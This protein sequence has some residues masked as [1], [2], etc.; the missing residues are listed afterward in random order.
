MLDDNN[1]RMKKKTYQKPAVRVIEME[2]ATL[3]AASGLTEDSTK[4]NTLN[5]IID[6]PEDGDAWN[7]GI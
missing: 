2:A 6:T 5:G 3:A 1:L 7:E 4:P